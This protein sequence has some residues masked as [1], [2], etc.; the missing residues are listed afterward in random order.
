[1]QFQDRAE[2]GR[3]LAQKLETFASQRD[4][5]LIALP[6]GGVPVAY[7]IGQALN[8]PL[9]V[10]VVRKLGVP[11]QE[12]LAMG[13]IAMGGT[14][15]FNRPLIQGLNLSEE[16][17]NRVIAREERELERRQ[18]LY[19]DARPFPDLRNRTVILVDDGLATGATMYVALQALQ[20]LNPAHLIVAVPVAA[21]QTCEQLRDEAEEVICAITPEPFD[22]VGRW[23]RNFSQVTDD[24]VI[25]LLN[26]ARDRN[27][28]KQSLPSSSNPAKV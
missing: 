18:H 11:G 19:R 2:A 1:M 20:Q 3:L 16:T 14:R 4:V 10:F 28:S 7:E 23:Y 26:R 21:R 6:G 8:L 17:I 24:E 13:A 27:Q 12:E 9:D 25:G 5:L 22:G 15:V